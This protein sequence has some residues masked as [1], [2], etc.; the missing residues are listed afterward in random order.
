MCTL[1]NLLQTMKPSIE[2]DLLIKNEFSQ[3][4]RNWSDV[5]I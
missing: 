5:G 3:S 2:R 4:Q 1:Q